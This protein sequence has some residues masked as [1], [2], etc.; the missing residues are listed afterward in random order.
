[1]GAE[2]VQCG[3]VHKEDGQVLDEERIP[4]Y[5]SAMPYAMESGDFKARAEQVEVRA[6]ERTRLGE[7]RALGILSWPFRCM[8]CEDERVRY[9]VGVCYR[10]TPWEA[11]P[12]EVLTLQQ[13]G[14]VEQMGHSRWVMVGPV[15][16][17]R[18]YDGD[19]AAVSGRGSRWRN[20]ELRSS[21]V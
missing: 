14:A 4:L 10:T 18:R 1:M 17:F 15:V 12:C 21:T 9:G 5:F 8:G 6:K 2:S 20:L 13:E 7:G 11:I 19:E 16:R 3:N